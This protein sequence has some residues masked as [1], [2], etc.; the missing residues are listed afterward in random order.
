MVLTPE[1]SKLY[2]VPDLSL[3]QVFRNLVDNAIAVHSD[4]I[5]FSAH[6]SQDFL[7]IKVKDRG[8]GFEQETLQRMQQGLPQNSDQGL[9]L[10]LALTKS[11]V[12]RYGGQ[13]EICT[14]PNSGTEVKV[15]LPLQEIRT[16]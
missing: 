4:G 9:G 3:E 11:A 7:E 6:C 10:G 5:E 8:P 14:R 15:Q 12:E 1:L 2:L 13:I 16:T